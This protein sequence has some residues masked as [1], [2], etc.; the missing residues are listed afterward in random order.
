M[1]MVVA[2]RTRDRKTEPFAIVGEIHLRMLS[3]VGEVDTRAALLAQI[4]HDT[5]LM[6]F[7]LIL[8][9]S[10]SIPAVSLDVHLPDG[11]GTPA[12]ADSAS[13]PMASVVLPRRAFAYFVAGCGVQREM[14]IAKN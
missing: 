8:H 9:P 6:L 4:V 12:F 13:D 2:R 7:Q 1:S 3:A 10:S 11:P 14:E 5:T